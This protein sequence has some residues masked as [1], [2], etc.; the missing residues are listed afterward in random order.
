MQ[1]LKGETLNKG[2]IFPT[3][4]GGLP[5]KT[6]EMPTKRFHV[7]PTPEYQQVKEQLPISTYKGTTFFWQ[8]QANGQ[9]YADKNTLNVDKN[10][11]FIDEKRLK[12]P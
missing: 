1:N 8:K 2:F 6:R 5:T 10:N 3:K 4:T 7:K 12:K 11:R 9:L